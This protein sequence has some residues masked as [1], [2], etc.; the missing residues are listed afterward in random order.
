MKASFV[1]FNFVLL[2]CFVS[3]F[4]Q[5]FADFET[6]GGA[7]GLSSACLYGG[8]SFYS[9]EIALRRGTDIVV[10]TPGRIKVAFISSALFLFFFDFIITLLILEDGV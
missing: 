5:V 2:L 3:S 6:Y 1:R 8:A 7:L 4:S 9:Q 10:G